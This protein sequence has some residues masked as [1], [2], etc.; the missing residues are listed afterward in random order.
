MLENLR[1]QNYDEEPIIRL[2]RSEPKKI[3]Q[4]KS[5]IKKLL[6]HFPYITEIR[7]GPWN[8]SGQLI[9]RILP[10]QVEINCRIQKDFNYS[11]F[12]TTTAETGWELLIVEKEIGEF[13]VKNY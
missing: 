1:P 13:L 10:N 9:Y 2:T 3:R 6:T 11:F 8:S 7:D 5:F 12:I 4:K